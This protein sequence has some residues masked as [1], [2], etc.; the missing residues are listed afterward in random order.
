[1][2]K[3]LTAAL[4]FAVT[5]T[6]AV[7]ADG[8]MVAGLQVV[9]GALANAD[10]MSLYTF[11]PDTADSSACNGPCAV[12]WPPLFAGTDDED[13]GEFTIVT[14]ADGSRQWAH[15]GAPLYFWKNDVEAG[16]QTGDGVK[17]VWHL[18]RP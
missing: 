12:A 17:G 11:D 15:D 2:Y 9:N 7:F 4:L 5:S 18:A 13:H 3:S 6:T 16:D 10:G 14:R 1:M 8:H